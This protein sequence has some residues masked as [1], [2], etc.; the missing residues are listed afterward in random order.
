M[1]LS[2]MDET[3]ASAIGAKTLKI[4]KTNSPHW[5]RV[6]VV[7]QD[8]CTIARLSFKNGSLYSQKWYK[9]NTGANH[10]VGLISLDDSDRIKWKFAFYR[11]T[12]KTLEDKVYNKLVLEAETL[13][14]T[15]LEK[16][17][18]ATGSNP[19]ATPLRHEKITGPTIQK[20]LNDLMMDYIRKV[21][22]E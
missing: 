11:A 1:K 7:R 22:K 19:R 15:E 16:R 3:L 6:F 2:E 8:G 20:Y 4:S 14:S 10:A 17:A 9:E 5:M 12:G 21:S 13:R 18:N